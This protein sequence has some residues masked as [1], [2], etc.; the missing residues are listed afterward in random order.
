MILI[1]KQNFIDKGL[2]VLRTEGEQFE[3]NNADRVKELVSKGVA[4][5]VEVEVKE[6]KS[7]VTKEEVKEVKPKGRPK[8]K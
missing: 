7:E 3:C 2:R 4:Y 1:A 6:V 8:Q 5:E